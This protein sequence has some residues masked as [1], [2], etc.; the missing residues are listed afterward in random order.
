[1]KI[2]NSYPLIVGSSVRLLSIIYF[3]L[4][5]RISTNF[6]G[7]ILRWSSIKV[8]LRFQF[9]AE[10]GGG[11]GGGCFSYIYEGKTSKDLVNNHRADLKMI[12]HKRSLGDP[13]QALFKL[14]RSIKN[15]ALSC[16]PLENKATREVYSVSH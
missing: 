4:L 1:M 9:H 7:M 13:P 3:K 10:F 5:D 2:L 8:V 11:V 15:I 14:Y 16:K 12:W 6:T